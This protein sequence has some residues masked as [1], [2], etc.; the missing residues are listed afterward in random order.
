MNPPE[1]VEAPEE[2]SEYIQNQQAAQLDEAY[3]QYQTALKRTFQNMRE[4]KLGEAG[5]SL[6]TIS[7]WLLSNAVDLGT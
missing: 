1:A 2:D 3:A 6:L 7:D 5:T 4:G